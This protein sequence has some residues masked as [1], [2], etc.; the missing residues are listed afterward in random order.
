[1]NDLRIPFIVIS[2]SGMCGGG[3]ILH[4]LRN[5]IGDPRNLILITGFR[6]K[7]L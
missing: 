3:R 5:G 2:A 7:I 1:L 4:H 6:R